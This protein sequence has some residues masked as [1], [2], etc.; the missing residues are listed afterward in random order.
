MENEDE[1]RHQLEEMEQELAVAIT[2]LERMIWLYGACGYCANCPPSGGNRYMD[3]PCKECR[4]KWR[5][6][7]GR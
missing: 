5:G 2:D 7:K 4:I 3:R 6:R 1:L